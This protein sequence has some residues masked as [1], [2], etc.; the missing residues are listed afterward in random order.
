MPLALTPED[1][2]GLPGANTYATVEEADA[3]HE[4][5][6]HA[7]T[8]TGATT[9]RKAAALAMATRILDTT[10]VFNGSEAFPGVQRL[11]WPRRQVP[12]MR[13]KSVG[14]WGVV[15]LDPVEIPRQLKD[16]TAELARKLLEGDRTAEPET[17]GIKSLGLG[18]G[19]LE[20]E[21]NPGD[22]P[23]LVPSL[24]VDMLADIGSPRGAGILRKVVRA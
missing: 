10:F 18:Q 3:Y 9:E 11:A 15:E 7:T 2:T 4:A 19:A 6:L 14:F 23:G 20:I 1:G 5:H 22:R 21:F 8:W 17:Q 13:R 12:D 24:V 16:A